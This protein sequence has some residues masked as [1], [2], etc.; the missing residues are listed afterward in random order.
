V[1]GR[2]VERI[3]SAKCYNAWLKIKTEIDKLGNP[4]TIKQCKLNIRN[5]KDSFK[6]AKEENTKTGNEAN[7]PEFYEILTRF[8]AK[9]MVLS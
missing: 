4:K 9:E 8:S 7:F 5:L 2:I 3:E 1:F 6:K